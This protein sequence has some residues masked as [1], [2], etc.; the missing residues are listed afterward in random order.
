M[1][2][3]LRSGLG[4]FLMA[5]VCFVI[6]GC[7]GTTGPAEPDADCDWVVGSGTSGADGLVTIDMGELGTFRARVRDGL[8]TEPIAGAQYICV[9]SACDDEAS[10]VAIGGDDYQVGLY[11]YDRDDVITSEGAVPSGW[12]E[13]FPWTGGAT[14]IP[15]IHGIAWVP[16]DNWDEICSA[17]SELATDEVSNMDDGLIA[18]A[19]AARDEGLLLATAYPTDSNSV[20]VY[21]CWVDYLDS[22]S[23]LEELKNG[24]Y[25]A[26]GYCGTAG[27]QACADGRT[28]HRKDPA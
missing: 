12:D 13:I 6:A 15:G 11:T 2:N 19:M 10:C 7:G 3:T 14:P 26:Q 9:A 18:D 4:V 23:V 22:G 17:L 21:I 25:L 8:T 5:T 16:E 28:E 27:G 24:V 20:L 1:L